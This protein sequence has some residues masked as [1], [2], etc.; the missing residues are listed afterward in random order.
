MNRIKKGDTIRIECKGMTR[1]VKVTYV[2]YD[3]ITSTVSMVEGQDV[4]EKMPV[5][6]KPQYD[7]GCWSRV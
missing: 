1:T 5:N 4:D 3:A 7:G 2:E 6:W